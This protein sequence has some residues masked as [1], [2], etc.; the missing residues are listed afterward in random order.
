MISTVLF[1]KNLRE[2]YK[3]TLVWIILLSVCGV[4]NVSVFSPLL[5]DGM[6]AAAQNTGNALVKLGGET[7]PTALAEFLTNYLYGFFMIVMLLFFAV[8]LAGRLVSHHVS[9][10]TMS[11]ILVAPC[12]RGKFMR[13]QIIFFVLILAVIT[14]AVM[15]ICIA[16]GE[17]MFPGKLDA[18]G[19]IWVNVSLLG[20]VL[21]AGALCMFFSCI[22]NDSAKASGCSLA[23]VILFILFELVSMAGGKF[24]FCSMRLR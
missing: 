2:S 10:G 17:Q 14:A 7:L 12:S 6:K 9:R 13:T 3:L 19:F 23:V 21:A 16:G 4:M 1:R 11:Y 15:G 20:V 8:I 18:E 24:A 5:Q 22:F